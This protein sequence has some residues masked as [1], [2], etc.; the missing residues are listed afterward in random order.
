MELWGLPECVLHFIKKV[1]IARGGAKVLHAL[2]TQP[3]VAFI[4]FMGHIN[5]TALC[6]CKQYEQPFSLLLSADVCWYA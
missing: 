5:C 3:C 6:W 2:A 4:L 1:L